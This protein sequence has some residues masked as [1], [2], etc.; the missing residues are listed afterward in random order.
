MGIYHYEAINSK[1]DKVKGIIE[2]PSEENAQAKL[3][4]QSLYIRSLQSDIAS[5]DRELFPLL[6][7][8]LYPISRKEIGIFSRQLATLLGAGISLDQSL[9]MILEQTKNKNFQKIIL[10][11]KQA[12]T[13]GKTL[14]QS[15]GEQ[16]KVFPPVYENMVRVGEATGSYERTLNRLAEIEEKNAELKSKAITAL[17]YPGI[18]LSVS[19]FVVIFL[20]T[21]VVPQMKLLFENFQGQLPWPTR[22]VLGLSSFMQTFWPAIILAMAGGVYFFHRFREKPA[23][24][25]KVDGWT[26]RIPLIGDLLRKIEISRF[27]RNFGILQESN[28]PLLQTLEILEGTVGNSIFADELHKAAKLISEGDKIRTALADSKIIDQMTFGMIAAGETTDRLSELLLKV[29]DIMDGEV[30]AAVRRMTSA[31][32]PLMLI[33]MG[34]LVAGIMISVILPIYKL[35]EM[36][37]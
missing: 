34:G 31:L 13:E 1:G 24:K 33:V 21:S 23:G 17:I 30:D 14:S 2:A 37:Q 35:T 29:A 3:R 11:M 5:R 32:E 18:M 10:Q 36:M 25:R 20:L 27:A 16:K 7:R 9:T 22:I 6:S 8:I 12:V 4:A 26:I 19:V 28:V 15:F